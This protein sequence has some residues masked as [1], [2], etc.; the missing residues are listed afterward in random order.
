MTPIHF[1]NVMYQAN[2][3]M[4]TQFTAAALESSAAFAGR[5]ETAQAKADTGG[6][7][8]KQASP[9]CIDASYGSACW[10]AT[11]GHDDEAANELLQDDKPAR[12]H[13]QAA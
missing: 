7:G 6:T 9:L 11:G 10:I 4:L 2:L 5:H 8:A 12:I 1:F 13:R 3:A